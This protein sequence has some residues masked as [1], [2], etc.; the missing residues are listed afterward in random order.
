MFARTFDNDH[1]TI[2]QIADSL[3]RTFAGFNDAHIN[4][5]PNDKD[6]LECVGQI[7]QIDDRNLVQTSD[8][9]QIVIMCDQFTLRCLANST[10]FISTGWSLNSGNSRLWISI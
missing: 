4:R 7:I 5:F 6:W 1:G 8:L 10:S 2:F 3:L 9:V